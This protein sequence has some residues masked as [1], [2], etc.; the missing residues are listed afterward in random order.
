MDGGSVWP[1]TSPDGYPA[2]YLTRN[3]GKTWQRQDNGLP[4]G[5]AWWTVKRQGMSADAHDPLGLYF[6]TTSGELWMSRGEG[7]KWACIARHLLE[8]YAIEAAEVA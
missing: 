3:G 6:G 7:V 2:A 5:Q 8:I 4:M 1:R